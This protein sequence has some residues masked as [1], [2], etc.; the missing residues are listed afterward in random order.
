[1]LSPR[2]L[3]FGAA[4]LFWDCAT[5]SAT[6]TLP[7]GLPAPLDAAPRTDRHWRERLQGSAL[8]VRPLAG[9]AGDSLEAFWRAA[10]RAYT[11]CALTF[12]G[13]KLA[14]VWGVAKLVRDALGEEYA[15]GLWSNSLHEQLAWRAADCAASG[16]PAPATAAAGFPSWSWASL[17]G[18][19]DVAP[20]VPAVPRFYAAAGHGGGQVRFRVRTPLFGRHQGEHSAVWSEEVVNM[21]RRLDEAAARVSRKAKAGVVTTIA[22]IPE[23]APAATEEEKRVFAADRPPELVEDAIPIQAHVCGGTLRAA[24]EKGQWVFAVEGGGQ[25]E[26]LFEAY[27]DTL[28]PSDE[29]PCELVLLAA[30]KMLMDEWGDWSIDEGC[31]EEDEIYDVHYSGAGILVER[32]GDDRFRRVGAVAFREVGGDGWARLRRACGQGDEMLEDELD[33]EDGR[34]IW[35][36]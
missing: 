11:A 33:V 29:T 2:L 27:P 15:A 9:T 34:K 17:R 32:A 35:L 22:P 14:A 12:Y 8:S 6:E 10:V 20:R 18:A 25:D 16:R 3:Q 28:P 4:Q 31:L 13:D 7:A 26:A 30:S 23:E 1:M 36:V 19:V 21:T 5:L 24:A